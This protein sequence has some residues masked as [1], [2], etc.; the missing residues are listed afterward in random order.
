MT[1]WRSGLGLVDPFKTAIEKYGVWPTTVW[2]CNYNDRLMKELKKLIG[3]LSDCPIPD[4]LRLNLSGN[5]TY[6]SM[7]GGK[8][9]KNNISRIN[10]QNKQSS[11]PNSCYRNIVNG[12]GKG[13]IHVSIFNPAVA[14][15][16]LNMYAPKSGRC[17]DPFAGGGTRGILSC[18]KGLFYEGVEIRLEE[19]EALSHR[20]KQNGIEDGQYKIYH[21]SSCNIPEIDS[22]SD[23]FLITCPPY[24]NLEMYGG[25]AEDLSML[26]TYDDFLS[27]LE[28]VIS[29]SYRILKPGSVSCW[30]VGLLRD[31]NGELLAMNHDVH[32]LHKKL[33]FKFKEEIILHLTS[34]GSIQRIGQ[35]E[36]GNKFL[37][38]THEYALVFI[39]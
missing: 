17:Y 11:G 27:K 12:E 15:W 26:P 30:V 5:K 1:I 20:F 25:G 23:D 38:R 9:Y 37:I 13:K 39:R 22:G 32:N 36:K 16:L 14:L 24:F 10:I 7:K 2:E 21:K 29:E 4:K 6:S 8:L 28:L 18:K 33:G 35:F 3:D 19:V 31:N 34:T